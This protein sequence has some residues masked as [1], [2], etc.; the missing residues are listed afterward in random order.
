MQLAA[1]HRAAGDVGSLQRL[2]VIGAS[3]FGGKMLI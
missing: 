1:W 2:V 3:L